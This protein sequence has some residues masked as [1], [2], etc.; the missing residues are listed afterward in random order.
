MVWIPSNLISF[1]DNER[2]AG[3]PRA[4]TVSNTVIIR[5]QNEKVGF[6]SCYYNSPVYT[7]SYCRV[8]A[9]GSLVKAR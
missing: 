7:Y 4:V 6:C 2:V 5:D 8:L 3:L 1:Y 9:N